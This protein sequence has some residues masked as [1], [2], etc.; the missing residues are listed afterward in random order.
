LP[1]DPS[2]YLFNIPFVKMGSSHR[3]LWLQTEARER[4]P[5]QIGCEL[6]WLVCS[7]SIILL[8]RIA[9]YSV[10]GFYHFLKDE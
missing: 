7:C 2:V 4:T 8:E 1:I 3:A 9:G 10:L 5:L 6:N